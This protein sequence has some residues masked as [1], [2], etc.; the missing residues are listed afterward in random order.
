MCRQS[1]EEGQSVTNLFESRQK[2]AVLTTQCASEYIG[3][4]ALCDR[5]RRIRFSCG[6]ESI[7]V[8]AG[9]RPAESNL[10][11]LQLHSVHILLRPP[12]R[13]Y[14]KTHHKLSAQSCHLQTVNVH[15]TLCLLYWYL[16]VVCSDFNSA[17]A[18]V[19]LFIRW[20]ESKPAVPCRT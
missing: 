12:F 18:H 1:A 15:C 3:V 2:R 8:S 19:P 16:T 20:H 6:P 7:Y 9:E 10:P 4:Q 5:I 14:I 17:H 13:Q 11:G